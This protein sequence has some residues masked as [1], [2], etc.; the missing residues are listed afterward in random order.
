MMMLNRMKLPSRL[1][2]CVICSAGCE[3]R[4]LARAAMITA[5]TE[6]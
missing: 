5:K 2:V 1:E 6:K 3:A 4:K